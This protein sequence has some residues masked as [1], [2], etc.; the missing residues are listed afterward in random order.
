VILPE[1]LVQLS[2]PERASEVQTPKSSN[3]LPRGADE[4]ANIHLLSDMGQLQLSYNYDYNYMFQT[5]LSTDDYALTKVIKSK[6]ST[7]TTT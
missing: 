3:Q 6:V 1:L 4:N 7:T 5:Q 2:Q